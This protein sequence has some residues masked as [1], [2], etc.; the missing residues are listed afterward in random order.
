MNSELIAQRKKAFLYNHDK[1]SLLIDV[2]APLKTYFDIDLFAQEEVLL[3]S[4]GEAIE[5]KTLITN[6][7]FLNSYIHGCDHDHTA[8]PFIQPIKEASLGS[9]SFFPW[10]DPNDCPFSQMLCQQFGFSRGLFVYKRY[11]TYLKAWWFVGKESSKIPAAVTKETLSPFQD[12]I[13]YF[14]AKQLFDNPFMGF[15]HPFDLSY[16]PINGYQLSKF[17]KSINLNKHSLVVGKKS[18][19]LSK[20]EW[21]CLSGMAQGKTYKGVAKLLSLS[22]RTVETYLN[23]IREKAGIPSKAKLVDYFIEQNQS[24]WG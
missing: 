1:H 10:S 23:Q 18:I 14:E 6:L 15:T 7:G 16:E 17:K 22:P 8:E 21:E 9:Y 11:E 4:K 3:N 12:F 13:H 19:L 2:T 24:F 5:Y 20:R